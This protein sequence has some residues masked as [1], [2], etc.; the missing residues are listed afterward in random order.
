M[1]AET[2]QRSLSQGPSQASFS[3][4]RFSRRLN[5][6]LFAGAVSIV[7]LLVI[8]G[9][10]LLRPDPPDGP[11]GD[12]TVAVDLI[13]KPSGAKIILNGRDTKLITPALLERIK[14]GKI[15]KLKLIKEEFDT[16]ETDLLLED[17]INAP[18]GFELKKSQQPTYQLT[19]RS[20]PAGAKIFLNG[21]DTEQVTPADFEGLEAG[22]D[23]VLSLYRKDYHGYEGTLQNDGQQDQVLDVKLKALT[24]EK[25]TVSSEPSGASIIVDG[26]DSEQ[27]TPADLLGIKIPRTLKLTLKKDGFEDTTTEVTVDSSDPREIKVEL[28]KIV[29]LVPLVITANV[30]GTQVLIDNKAVGAAP[31]TVTLAV[32][33]YR[34]VVKRADYVTESRLITLAAEDID[35][36]LH[37]TLKKK[38]DATVPPVVV[39]D[40]PVITSPSSGALLA[41]LRVDS[42]P[43]GAS[44][45]I[46]GTAQGIT[47]ILISKL[48]KGTLITVLVQK[49]GYRKWQKHITLSKDNTEVTAVLQPD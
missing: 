13:S 26:V 43:S 21:K 30:A 20:E 1:P 8:V 46:D 22:K 41:R 47:P 6:G 49:Q 29:V 33:T 2:S 39:A 5:A 25:L 7:L 38:E 35:Q 11:E 42:N 28:K 48:K 3:R 18:L 4:P 19:V 34:V 32:G 9:Y 15:Y 44:V 24:L 45:K 10:F 40:P 31:L 23:Y 36:T 12:L 17:E 14:I 37:F 27:E 16:F